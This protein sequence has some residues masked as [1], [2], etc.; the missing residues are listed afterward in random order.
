M[1]ISPD[2]VLIMYVDDLLL[3][4]TTNER[5][6]NLILQLLYASGFKVSREKLQVSRPSVTFMGRLITAHSVISFVNMAA[7]TFSPL[8]QWKLAKICAQTKLTWLSV[9]PL[10]LMFVRSSVKQDLWFHTIWIAYRSIIPWTFNATETW[11]NHTFITLCLFWQ[12]NC[13]D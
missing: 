3:A 8:R 1:H 9:L 7:F 11:P 13:S 12:T 2:C 10:I 6:T 5:A 4:A